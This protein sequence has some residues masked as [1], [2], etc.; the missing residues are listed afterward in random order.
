[1]TGKLEQHLEELGGDHEAA[2]G[3]IRLL[4]QGDLQQAL[5]KGADAREADVRLHRLEQ[6]AQEHGRLVGVAHIRHRQH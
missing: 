6:Q 2:T 4:V 1:M 5:D 3:E